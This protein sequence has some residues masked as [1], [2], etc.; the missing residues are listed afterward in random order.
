MDVG[1]DQPAATAALES[2]E[3][4]LEDLVDLCRQLNGQG[5]QYIVVGGFAM[6][7]VGYI[8]RTMDIDL[9]IATGPENEARVFRA[10]ESLPDRAVRELRPGDVALYAL[11]RV[12]D[13]IVVDL[14]GAAGGVEYREAAGDV[15]VHEIDGVAIP[16][17][18][19]RLLWRTKRSSLRDKDKPDLHF[20]RLLFQQSGEQPPE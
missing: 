2:R 13:E 3:P 1:D 7:A 18:S 15:A 17:A 4:A 16:F 10:L 20:L 11:V 14:M 6:R 19:A 9:L 8:R 12:A 5:A